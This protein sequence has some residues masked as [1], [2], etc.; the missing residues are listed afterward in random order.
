MGNR[1]NMFGIHIPGVCGS[2]FPSSKQGDIDIA[3]SEIPRKKENEWK[4]GKLVRIN[5]IQFAQRR[6]TGFESASLILSSDTNTYG[7]TTPF[8]KEPGS[9][10]SFPRSMRAKM[11]FK[12]KGNHSRPPG[13]DWWPAT[14]V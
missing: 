4:W 13:A 8:G 5:L 2:I 14:T 7:S 11:L 3:R 12:P 1:K 9:K 10:I 6:E